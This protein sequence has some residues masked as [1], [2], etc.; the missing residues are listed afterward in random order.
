MRVHRVRRR[1]QASGKLLR[2]GHAEAL[3]RHPYRRLVIVRAGPVLPRHQLASQRKPLP[4]VECVLRRGCHVVV[5]RQ[6]GLHA[7]GELLAQL[8]RV[9]HLLRRLRLDGRV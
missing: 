4:L 7:R 6:R 2:L 3:G 5:V 1:I 8:A 9:R